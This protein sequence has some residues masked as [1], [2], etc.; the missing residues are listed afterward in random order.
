MSKKQC[1]IS[2]ILAS[3]TAICDQMHLVV[4]QEGDASSTHLKID[5]LLLLPFQFGLCLFPILTMGRRQYVLERSRVLQ[6][7][8]LLLGK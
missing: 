8:H 6:V 4:S 1:L 2:Q 5:V 7:A 3:G